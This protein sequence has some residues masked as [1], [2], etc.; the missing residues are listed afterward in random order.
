MKKSLLFV[1][2]II[3]TSSF[4]QQRMILGESFSQASCP[5]CAAQNPAFQ[6]LVEANDSKIITIKYQT[7]W[8]GTDPMNAQNAAEIANRVTYYN[9]SGVPDRIQDGT[10]MAI[11]QSSIDTRFAVSSPVS[12]VATHTIDE[13]ANTMD[14]TVTVSA[15]AP[16]SPTNTVLQLGMVEQTIS[17]ATPPG[18][19]G[20]TVFHNVMRKMFP[21]PTGTPVD[22]ANFLVA[23]G[24]QTFTFTDLPIPAYI[25]KKSEIGFVAWV[26]NNTTKEVYQAGYSAP[27]INAAIGSTGAVAPFSCTLGLTNL[28]V[29]LENNGQTVITSANVNYSVNGGA[30]SQIPFA[31]SIAVN[32]TAN[33]VIP[34]ISSVSGTNSLEI[35]LT[36]INGSTATDEISNKT[37]TFT[38]VSTTPSTTPLVQNFTTAAFPYAHYGVFSPSNTNWTRSTAN[39]GS[40]KFDCFNYQP[41]STGTV[42]IAPVN[43]S[44]FTNP[45]FTFDV[46]SAPYSA[47]PEN[48]RLEVLV[49]TDC[50]ATWTSVYNKAGGTLNTVTTAITSGFTPTAAQWRNETVNIAA[51]ASETNVLIGFKGT[52]AYGNNIYVDNINIGNSTASI[53]EATI[54]GASVYPNPAS[55]D[56]NVSFNAENNNY[57]V[58]LM[59]LA[60]RV[61]ETKSVTNASNQTSVSFNVSDL[62]AGNYFVVITT[63]GA[64]STLKVAVK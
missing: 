59:D 51:Y 36:N 9:V 22:A 47:T 44:S 4:A 13:V 1:A 24:T 53:S 37:I 62:S 8:P 28:D 63:E 48:D 41:N 40:L 52:S 49:S 21:S 50:G 29:E 57:E 3:A 25:Y 39:T 2:A 38:T 45:S 19:N 17:F 64:Q 54:T 33:V 27:L 11:T 10:N 42:T 26:Q 32:G 12:L 7:S 14:V 61:L 34:S 58:K 60:G 16:W 6:A 5:P 30:T 20:E 35:W 46:A 43:F 18:S 15:P 23:A 56:L 31:G 55:G